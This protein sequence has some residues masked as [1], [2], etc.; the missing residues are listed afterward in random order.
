M[1]RALLVRVA[2]PDDAGAQSQEKIGPGGLSTL[3]LGLG[4]RSRRPLRCQ[5]R[6]EVKLLS[7]G[8]ELPQTLLHSSKLLIAIITEASNSRIFA[9]AK[10]T[11]KSFLS[12][13][14]LLLLISP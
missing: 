6:G 2:Q 3:L 14:L 8:R 12:F 4:H 1:A 13:G 5:A 9:V 7:A 10:R 11:L